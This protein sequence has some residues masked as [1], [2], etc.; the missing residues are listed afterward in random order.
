MVL[1]ALPPELWIYGFAGSVATQSYWFG[2]ALSYAIWLS[3]TWYYKHRN[4]PAPLDVYVHIAMPGMTFLGALVGIVFVWFFQT[5]RF[6]NAQ[7]WDS[8][9]K[10][11]PWFILL[12]GAALLLTAGVYAL[13]AGD[14]TLGI[15]LTVSFGVMT[16]VMI[17][18]YIFAKK[19]IPDGP[20]QL[21]YIILFSLVAILPAANDYIL[22]E[23]DGVF[24]PQ[25]NRPWNIVAW[26]GAWV[27]VLILFILG[28]R[29]S[30]LNGAAEKSWWDRSRSSHPWRILK[31]ERMVT[32][33]SF[34][35][36]IFLV[37]F[38]A[39]IVDQILF[40]EHGAPSATPGIEAE[41]IDAAL[42][43]VSVSSAFVMV[44]MAVWF[45]INKSRGLQ[46]WKRFGSGASEL[47]WI[48]ELSS[49]KR[50]DYA[51]KKRHGKHGKHSGIGYSGHGDDP[52]R[53]VDSRRTRMKDSDDDSPMWKPRN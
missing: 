50:A 2:I 22:A 41:K 52:R 34:F 44:V 43:A 14:N 36:T 48:D 12:V 42:I 25:E 8:R 7:V 10:A 30:A 40:I 33:M 24:T 38:P 4:D 45:F 9:G 46:V 27:V 18:I 29:L 15:P 51:V 49:K 20:A 28:V 35:A 6:F 32:V 1:S 16:L 11:F 13:E 26:V 23:G 5:P 37:Y 53:F 47:E 39:L 17:G 21:K 19:W 3:N 31:G